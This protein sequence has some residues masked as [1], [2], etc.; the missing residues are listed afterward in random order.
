MSGDLNTNKILGAGLATALV[1]LGVR[2]VSM[3]LFETETPEKMGY[4]I[5]VAEGAGDSGAAEV[6]LPPDWGTVLASANLD[7]GANS[8]KKCA[9]CHTI[10]QGGANGTGPNLWGVVGNVPASHAGFSY[11]D[12]MSGHAAEAPAWTYDE[13][14]GFLK[15]PGKWISGTKM[16]FAG[17][18][19]QEERINLIAWLRAQDSSPAPI[20]APDPSRSPAAAAPAEA[21]P[22][23]PAEGE[24][25][26]AAGG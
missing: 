3:R 4:A 9:S 26:P 1:I 13:L 22:A 6:E 24:T 25:A 17:I 19:S 23:A 15:A 18:K 2:E 10:E 20:P 7:A 11:S 16:S 14:D 12:A 5:Q 21:A 8:F